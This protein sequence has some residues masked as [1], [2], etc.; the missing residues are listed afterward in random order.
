MPYVVIRMRDKL[1]LH[2]VR[3]EDYLCPTLIAWVKVL[4]GAGRLIERGQTTT[5][6]YRNTLRAT[7]LKPV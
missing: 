3:V 2:R 1:A 7:A 5:R 4:V 6:N